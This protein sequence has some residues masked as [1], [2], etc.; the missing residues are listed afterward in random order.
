M[1]NWD[2]IIEEIMWRE[3]GGDPKT[4]DGQVSDSGGFTRYGISQNSGESREFIKS[5]DY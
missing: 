3:C 5:L 2:Q 1:T 4:T